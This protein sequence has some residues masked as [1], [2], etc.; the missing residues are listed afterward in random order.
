[1][2]YQPL[3]FLSCTGLVAANVAHWESPRGHDS[4]ATPPGCGKTISPS[5]TILKLDCPDCPGTS[6]T[7]D[8]PNSLIYDITIN[9]TTVLL[10]SHP[11][12]PAPRRADFTP[13]STQYPVQIPS[14]L[15]LS[16]YMYD[17]ALA[18]PRFPSVAGTVAL[19]HQVFHNASLGLSIT[20]VQLTLIALSNT[21]DTG[22]RR[23]RVAGARLYLVQTDD[24]PLT[25]LDFAIVPA[26]HLRVT[27]RAAN[28]NEE[29]PPALPAPLAEV[30][31]GRISPAAYAAA[32]DRDKLGNPCSLA[33][34]SESRTRLRPLSLKLVAVAAAA[35]V[36]TV[37]LVVAAA[38]LWRRH[39]CCGWGGGDGGGEREKRVVGGKRYKRVAFE[40]FDSFI[41]GEEEEGKDGE[42][43]RLMPVVEYEDR[44]PREI[45]I[46]DREEGMVGRGGEVW[47][48][49]GVE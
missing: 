37:L 46:V 4:M 20:G 9:H 1:M 36:V 22:N 34:P 29:N 45:D 31:A 25:L 8:T 16:S 30:L 35:T 11:I 33:P 26:H 43:G 19:A 2:L 32:D 40:K 14:S 17:A 12:H 15:S 24:V 48:E 5:R 41:G 10:H 38:L 23:G 6:W 42:R 44:S 27:A 13:L 3:V 28:D 49:D 21:H 39:R 18:H 47:D 7:E